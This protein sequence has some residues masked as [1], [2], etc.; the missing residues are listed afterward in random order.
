MFKKN[1][2]S[3]GMICLEEFTNETEVGGGSVLEGHC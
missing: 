2:S 1:L 3:V